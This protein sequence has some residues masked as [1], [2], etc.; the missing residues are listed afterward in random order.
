[1]PFEVPQPKYVRLV[2]A[3]QSQIEDGTYPPG[4]MLPSEHQ[5]VSRFGMSRPT[6]VRALQILRQDGWIE[7]QQGRGT[8]VR[9]RPAAERPARARRGFEVVSRDEVETPGK[10]VAALAVKL[11]THVASVL[12][13]PRG[14][15]ALLRRWLTV[16]EDGPVELVSSYFPLELAD[17]TELGAA[18]PLPGGL[19]AH[20]QARGI[21]ID[22]V[23]ERICARAATD[24]EAS[25]LELPDGI[26]V[27]GILVTSRDAAGRAWHVADVAIPGDRGELEDTYSVR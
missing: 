10:L 18:D 2:Q 24:D 19:L 11:P 7:S 4:S 26:P 15:K 21:V 13:V 5:L 1:M 3:I 9:G 14:S 8:F 27:L 22:T 12:G 25:L 23:G 17:R 6:V 20:L 16:D